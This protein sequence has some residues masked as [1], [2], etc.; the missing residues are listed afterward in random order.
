[1][2][3]RQHTNA[4]VVAIDAPPAAT[5]L[6]HQQ[7]VDS[8]PD[9]LILAQRKRDGVTLVPTSIQCGCT[10]FTHDEYHV[11][12]RIKSLTGAERH[13]RQ[14]ELQRKRSHKAVCSN[15]VAAE[16]NRK[17]RAE[18]A[19]KHRE[20]SRKKTKDTAAT[21]TDIVDPLPLLPPL[22]QLLF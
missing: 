20:R 21:A 5:V 22:R 14:T 6:V 15:N 18:A 12:D 13:K 1:M 2:R 7:R 16:Q 11:T 9:T 19:R 10:F 4:K 3:L 8:D 17:R